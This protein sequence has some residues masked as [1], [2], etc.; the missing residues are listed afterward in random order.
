M[1]TL[2]WSRIPEGDT[3][4]QSIYYK[5]PIYSRMSRQH[6]HGKA[7]GI[8][9]PSGGRGF[10][11]FTALIARFM[12]PIWGRQ[13]PGG[14]HVGPMNLANWV[15]SLHNVPVVRSLDVFL[16]VNENKLLDKLSSC[17]LFEKIALSHFCD[18]KWPPCGVVSFSITHSDSNAKRW[19]ITCYNLTQTICI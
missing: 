4:R 2:C 3:Q 5:T 19:Y 14:A 10:H 6:C 8:T 9:G 13:D 17:M 12:G 1:E 7:L 11:R 15:A 16:S 18:N